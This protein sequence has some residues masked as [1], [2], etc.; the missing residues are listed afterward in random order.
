MIR[1]LLAASLALGAAISVGG[2]TYFVAG[3]A[4]AQDLPRG[5]AREWPRT[6]FSKTVVDFDEILSGGPPKDG[7]PAVDDPSF[8]AAA[9]ETRLEGR[10]P[11]MSVEIGGEA[12]A[13]PVRYLM[14]HEI[15]NDRIGDAPFS[16]TF[17]PL[18]NSGL[19]FDGR[20][21]GRE[22]TFGVSGKLRFSDMVMY[23]RQTES[24]WQQFTGAGIVGALTGET[25]TVIPSRLE[26]WD[27]FKARASNGVVM[28]QPVGVRRNYGFNP[29]ANY[30]S[31]A[32][33]FL[34]SGSPPPHDIPA[35][36]RVLRVGDRAWPLSRL[37]GRDELV[38]DGVRITWAAGQASALDARRIAEGRDVGTV[39][40][41]DA[42]TGALLPHEVV[43]AFAFQAFE[44]EGRWM[45]G[46][47]G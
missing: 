31:S 3:P 39:T 27:A 5:W 45:I 36:A 35:L 33:P 25:L 13:Y 4:A 47:G 6:D 23:D 1:S 7:I 15:V 18:C 22:L 14:W 34:Y 21:G 43:F 26:S 28:D 24:W 20:H 44:P 10:E 11:V 41:Y 19:V 16:V 8:L 37:E 46:E 32:W 2:A 30:D 12:R 40:A 42:A 29:Y 38:E 9:D 17:C